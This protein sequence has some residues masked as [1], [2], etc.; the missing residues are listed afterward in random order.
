MS[1]RHIAVSAIFLQTHFSDMF[2]HRDWKTLSVPLDHF[3]SR[4]K[5]RTSRGVERWN[6]GCFDIV[7]SEQT[8]VE[9][10]MITNSPSKKWPAIII[11]WAT[12]ATYNR[13]FMVYAALVPRINR[14]T[15]ST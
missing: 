4:S 3:V 12:V 2:N 6:V 9:N 8:S 11:L 13:P 14:R 10:K 7:Y 5:R 15:Y 1:K